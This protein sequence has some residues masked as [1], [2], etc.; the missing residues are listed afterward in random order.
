MVLKDIQK[1]F[2]EGKLQRRRQRWVPPSPSPPNEEGGLVQPG[3]I[4]QASFRFR[5]LITHIDSERITQ[6]PH[7]SKN[8]RGGQSTTRQV[9][10]HPVAQELILG[11]SGEVVTVTEGGRVRSSGRAGG[12]GSSFLVRK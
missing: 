9:S 12:A 4:Q 2:Q 8:G 3:K 6:A 5:Q 7:S 11:R 1:W 10:K